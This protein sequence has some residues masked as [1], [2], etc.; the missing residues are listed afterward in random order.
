MGEK[1]RGPDLELQLVRAMKEDERGYWG[2][3]RLP[4]IAPV[5]YQILRWAMEARVLGDERRDVNLLVWVEIWCVIHELGVCVLRHYEELMRGWGYKFKRGDCERSLVQT[6]A[7]IYF[8]IT[9]L[10][11]IRERFY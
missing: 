5:S 7:F 9:A 1:G 2:I 11:L 8:W 3:S 10:C 6:Y 4:R